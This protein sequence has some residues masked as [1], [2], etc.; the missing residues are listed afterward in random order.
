[1]LCTWFVKTYQV[2]N[3]VCTFSNYEIWF[4]QVNRMPCFLIVTV[5]YAT[6]TP[7]IERGSAVHVHNIRERPPPPRHEAC[8]GSHVGDMSVRRYFMRRAVITFWLRTSPLKMYQIF[9]YLQ[10]L[11]LLLLLFKNYNPAHVVSSSELYAV[12]IFRMRLKDWPVF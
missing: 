9:I 1:M 10:L 11:L 5:Q 12:P 2:N 4:G 3:S 7:R 6:L 8:A